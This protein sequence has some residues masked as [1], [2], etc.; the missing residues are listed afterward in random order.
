M[1]ENNLK[2]KDNV[3]TR[4]FIA[5]EMPDS[6]IKEVARINDVL[7]NWK[8]TGKFTELENLHLTLK[9]LGEIDNER[10]EKVKEKLRD[11]K[12]ES[13]EAKLSEI[14]TFSL[15]ENPRIIWIKIGGKGIFELQ[16][17]IDN[18][19]EKEGFLREKRFMSHM[20]IARVK[21]VK[22]K[23]G[24]F[25]YVKKIRIKEIK[26]RINNFYLK[27]SELNESGPIYTTLETYNMV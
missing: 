16:E 13:F 1:E 5:I 8:F 20:T 25:D 11:V 3:F 27:K 17:K 10:L 18:T 15:H 14:G 22:D 2:V 26:F 9:F 21:Y 23:K 7:G 4:A 6:V 12:F 19:L 24:F